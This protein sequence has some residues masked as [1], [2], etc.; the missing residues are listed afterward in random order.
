M[1]SED[2]IIIIIITFLLTHLLSVTKYILKSF[3]VFYLSEIVGAI[4]Q[5]RAFTNALGF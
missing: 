4:A 3:N 1:E 2:F 5:L